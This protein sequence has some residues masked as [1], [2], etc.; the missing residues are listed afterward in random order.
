[1]PIA[2]GHSLFISHSWRQSDGYDRLIALL[3]EAPD[4]RF[5]DNSVPKDDPIQNAPTPEALS[6][7]L[8]ARI[9]ASNVVL[10]VASMTVNYSEWI[11][12]EIELCRS[13]TRKPLIGL[14]PH[15]A[16]RAS[17]Y[18]RNHADLMVN[19]RTDEIIGAI[20]HLDP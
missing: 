19:W 10:V 1:M 6:A 7:A 15:Q 8:S 16:E 9:E 14:I 18:V 13:I 2:T 3:R 11:E 17:T 4:F 12:R 20:R 5:H